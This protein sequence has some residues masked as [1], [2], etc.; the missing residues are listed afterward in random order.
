MGHLGGSVSEASDFS[1]V[2]DL[3]VP[4][5]SSGLPVLGI[6]S[7]CP[8]LTHAHSLVQAFVLSK[9]INLKKK[10]LLMSYFLFSYY[11]SYV[12]IQKNV[13]CKLEGKNVSIAFQLVPGVS[14]VK[15]IG[16]LR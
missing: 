6:L 7:L 15:L 9:Y 11:P 4:H 5:M 13:L 14:Q 16:I 3:K 2:H 12:C 1:S 8:S 10:N